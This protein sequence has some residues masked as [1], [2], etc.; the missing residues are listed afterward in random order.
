MTNISAATWTTHIDGQ[1]VEIPAT[2]DGIQATLDEADV[3]VRSTPVHDLHR[4]LARWALPEEAE[5]EDDAVMA[6]LK[7]GDFSS[8][9]PQDGE[10]RTGVA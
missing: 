5:D 4:V 10:R 1:P 8:C 9:V 2:I 3:E 7:A 6:R